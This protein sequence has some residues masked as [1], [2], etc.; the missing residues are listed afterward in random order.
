M[1]AA[2]TFPLDPVRL[3]QLSR[4]SAE[5]NGTHAPPPIAFAITVTDDGR[6]TLPVPDHSRR[7]SGES[8]SIDQLIELTLV[9]CQL[10]A[11]MTLQ[12]APMVAQSGLLI[13]FRGGPPDGD[14]TRD[15]VAV[16]MTRNGLGGLIRDLQA[17]DAALAAQGVA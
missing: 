5:I 7:A 4:L 10:H 3:A 1:S 17:I 12:W 16:F 2:D 13:E 6:V 11:G 8:G 15:A 14:E 9:S